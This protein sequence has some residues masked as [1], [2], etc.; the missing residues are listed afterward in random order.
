MINCNSNG[1]LGTWLSASCPARMLCVPKKFGV[2][3][4]HDFCSCHFSQDM[5]VNLDDGDRCGPSASTYIFFSFW[6]ILGAWALYLCAQMVF[7]LIKSKAGLL[8]SK[9][10]L[11]FTGT[12]TYLACAFL[13]ISR[14]LRG[15][16]LLMFHHDHYKGIETAF[17]VTQG[18]FAFFTIAEATFFHHTLHSALMNTIRMV[19]KIADRRRAIIAAVVVA[20]CCCGAFPVILNKTRILTSGY[21]GGL[22]LVCLF[23]FTRIYRVTK[24]HI[25]PGEQ[26]PTTTKRNTGQSQTMILMIHMQI[27]RV[28]C[29]L[30]ALAVLSIID[31]LFW[32]FGRRAGNRLLL[33]QLPAVIGVL[34]FIV[35]NFMLRIAVQ[36]I[37]TLVE[38]RKVGDR[39]SPAIATFGRKSTSNQPAVDAT[40]EQPKIRLESFSISIQEVA[41]ASVAPS[42]LQPTSDGTLAE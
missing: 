15:A 32:F 4:I 36:T 42:P 3:Q 37:A 14:V 12:L 27:K 33:E 8:C 21:L 13:A 39:R 35:F 2:N 17:A 26:C 29:S 6:M 28:M 7:V 10:T 30:L 25:S 22:S 41:H 23:V 19:P 34:T 31:I 5:M 16:M 40:Q 18:L 38:N 1:V 24:Q 9:D 20:L 11:G